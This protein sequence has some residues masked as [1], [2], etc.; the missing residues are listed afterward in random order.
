M[1]SDPTSVFDY[2]LS[3]RLDETDSTEWCST[4]VF[5]PWE[6][7]FIYKNIELDRGAI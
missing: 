1:R 3:S 2:P 5:V 7:V 6:D 4:D